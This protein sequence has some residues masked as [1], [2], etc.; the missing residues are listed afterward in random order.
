MPIKKIIRMLISIIAILSLSS[1]CVCAEPID[2]SMMRKDLEQNLVDLEK[3]FLSERQHYNLTEDDKIKNNLKLGEIY[4]NNVIDIS[5]N[6]N[7]NN[8]SKKVKA[9]NKYVS[10]IELYT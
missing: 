3:I 8:L 6:D 9:T 4:I 5:T 1:V 10:T 7:S 2:N